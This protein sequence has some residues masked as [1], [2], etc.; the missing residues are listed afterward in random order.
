M[1]GPKTEKNSVKAILQGLLALLLGAIGR[2]S[3][4]AHRIAR[5]VRLFGSG[6]VEARP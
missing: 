3:L 4:R 2:Y 5:P 6:G 1:V